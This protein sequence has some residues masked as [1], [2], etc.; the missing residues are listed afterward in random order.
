MWSVGAA[1]PPDDTWDKAPAVPERPT[2]GQLVSSVSAL[3]GS[4][5]P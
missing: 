4:I 5:A 2:M 1:I 3:V